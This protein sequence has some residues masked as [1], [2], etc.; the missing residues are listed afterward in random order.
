[1]KCPRCRGSLVKNYEEVK[2]ISCGKVIV[3][4]DE[5]TEL[6]DS[7]TGT[8]ETTRPAHLRRYAYP[9]TRDDD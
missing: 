8:V 5:L 4:D 2:C 6:L 3:E 7:M 1:M 9:I